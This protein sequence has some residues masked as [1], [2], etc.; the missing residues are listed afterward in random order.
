MQN[1]HKH[2]RRTGSARDLPL[3]IPALTTQ[4]L[5]DVI[6]LIMRQIMTW[7]TWKEGTQMCR[8]WCEILRNLQTGFWVL[9]SAG[10]VSMCRTNCWPW[11]SCDV[12][13][14]HNMVEWTAKSIFSSSWRHCGNVKILWVPKNRE[15]ITTLS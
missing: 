4:S 6:C 11:M 15:T 10:G 12:T 8:T 1:S 13:C 2:E 9:G 7:W 3:P 14:I 5:T